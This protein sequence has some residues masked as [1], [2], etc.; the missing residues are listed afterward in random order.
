[1][2]AASSRHRRSVGVDPQIAPEASS[3]F[4]SNALLFVSIAANVARNAGANEL[5][6]VLITECAGYAFKARA[7][8]GEGGRGFP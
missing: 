8:S 4:V 5:R 6:H 7:S 1:M 2:L 3:A